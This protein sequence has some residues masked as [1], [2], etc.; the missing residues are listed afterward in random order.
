MMNAGSSANQAPVLAAGF[1]ALADDRRSGR[2]SFCHSFDLAH[3]ED[4]SRTRGFKNAINKSA[5][6]V[7]S[8]YM[9]PTSSTAP[10]V[11]ECRLGHCAKHRGSQPGIVEDLFDTDDPTEQ[12]ADLH[13]DHRD[14]GSKRIAQDMR[15][16]HF[17]FRQAFHRGGSHIV[18]LQA[19]RSLRR[20]SSGR[21]SQ[22]TQSPSPRQAA[23]SIP[24]GRYGVP[25]GGLANTLPNRNWMANSDIKSAAVTNSGIDEVARP[26]LTTTRSAELVLPPSRKNSCGNRNRDGDHE[27]QAAQACRSETAQG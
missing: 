14:R 15:P 2:R 9:T 5:S 6:S 3:R 18:R 19:S 12:V 22:N 13:A 1:L 24:A 20:G 23:A 10:A 4:S 8:M 11:P 27:R 26:T 7:D 25:G 16:H 17:A 21:C